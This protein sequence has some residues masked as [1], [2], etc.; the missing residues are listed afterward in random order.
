MILEEWFAF[1]PRKTSDEIFSVWVDD[2]KR[3]LGKQATINH[4][5]SVWNARRPKRKQ[6]LHGHSFRIGGASL[7]WNLGAEREEVMKCGRRASNAY[8]VY[9]RKFSDSEME[10]TKKLLLDL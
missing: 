3:R 1:R 8:L 7:R 5:R 10:K 9:L 2:K 6:L 4:L